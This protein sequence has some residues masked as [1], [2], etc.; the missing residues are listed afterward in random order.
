MS[1][2][3]ICVFCGSRNGVRPAYQVMAQALGTLL[4]EREIELVYGGGNVGLMGLLADACLA[5][6]GRVVGVIPR[7]LMEWEV[8]HEGLTRLEI[9]DSMHTRKA[10]MAELA[11]GFIALPGGMGTF[12]ELFEIL[13]WA[14]LG[15]HA[16]PVALLDVEG[17]YAPLV[18]MLERGVSE[19]F[20]K[21]ENRGLLLH[22]DN[23]AELLREMAHYHP[24]TVAR[25]LKDERQL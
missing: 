18:Q 13:S 10:R 2:K 6:G 15:F 23:P 17:Y 8:G 9:V 12:E 21:P 24:P 1:L 4:A 19:G 25:R 14:Q 22:G 7:A 3:H 11:E 20:M 5:A 16:K